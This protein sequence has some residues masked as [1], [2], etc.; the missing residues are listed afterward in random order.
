MHRN[1]LKTAVLLAS[2]AASLILVGY[3]I[4]GGTTGSVIGV[5]HLARHQRLLVLQQRQ[6]GAA[7]DAAPS[8]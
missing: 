4:G 3:L 6:A 8:R 5:R 1:G 7:L 2:L